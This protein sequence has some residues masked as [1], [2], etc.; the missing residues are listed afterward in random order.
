LNDYGYPIPA[1][2][3]CLGFAAA[4]PPLVADD[5]TLE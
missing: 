3:R 4:V 5:P 1:E 2:K